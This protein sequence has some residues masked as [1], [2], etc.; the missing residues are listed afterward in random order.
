MAKKGTKALK[1]KKFSSDKVKP[2]RGESLKAGGGMET[3]AAVGPRL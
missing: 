1:T 3:H 2:H